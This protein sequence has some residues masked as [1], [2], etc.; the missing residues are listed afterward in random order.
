MAK[1]W[2]TGHGSYSKYFEYDLA[3]PAIAKNRPS[4]FGQLALMYDAIQQR[5]LWIQLSH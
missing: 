1:L 4:I 2:D 3:I 5:L